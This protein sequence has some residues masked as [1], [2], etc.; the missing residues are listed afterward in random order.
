MGYYWQALIPVTNDG[1][2]RV[3][4]EQNGRMVH[5]FMVVERGLNR[6]HVLVILLLRQCCIDDIVRDT[7]PKLS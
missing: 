5:L 1:S 2:K 6:K 7:E 4:D 3:P